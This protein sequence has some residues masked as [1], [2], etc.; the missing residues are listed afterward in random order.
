MAVTVSSIAAFS[1][2]QPR[3]AAALIMAYSPLTWYAATGTVDSAF[4]A[5]TT[6]R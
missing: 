1:S 6:S 5:A 3:A 2:S 4:T